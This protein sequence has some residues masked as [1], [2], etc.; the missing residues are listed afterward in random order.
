MSLP[1]AYFLTWSTYG[2]WLPGDRRGWVDK[3]HRGPHVPFQEPDL[4]RESSAR[5]RMKESAVVL[6][7]ESRHV[8][9]CAIRETCSIRGWFVHALSVRSNHVHVVIT[10]EDVNPGEV[11]RAI[12]A[13]GTRALNQL[14][15]NPP[16][17]H[18]WT[19]GGSKR[20]LNDEKSIQAAIQYV[21]TQDQKDE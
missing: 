2:T 9:D 12:K 11:L 19:E 14:H 5:T 20:Y 17:K 4:E 16:R 8:A 18:W 10:A 13:Y 6:E 7:M 15:S 3:H 1:L 21:E